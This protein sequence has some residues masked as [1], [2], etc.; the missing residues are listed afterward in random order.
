MTVQKNHKN[1]SKLSHHKRFKKELKPPLL[2]LNMTTYSWLNE[3]MPEMLWAVLVIGNVERETALKFFRVIAGFV[4][5]NPDCSDVTHTGISKFPEGKT[6]E[7]I[8]LATGWSEEIKNVLRPLVWFEKLPVN[9]IWK[10][11]LGESPDKNEDFNKLASGVTETYWH[12]SESATDCRWIKFFCQ[13][14][15]GKMSFTKRMEDKVRGVFEYPNYGDLREIRPFIRASEIMPPDPDSDKPFH[16]DW[17]LS[18]WQQCFDETGCLPEESVNKKIQKRQDDLS[19]EL[20]KSRE[21]LLKQTVELRH[22]LIDHFF[23]EGKTSAIDARYETSFGITLYGLSLYIEIIFYTVS[24]SITGR[25]AMRALVECYITLK[26]LLEKEKSEPKIWDTFREYGNGQLKLLYL[27]LKET[28][29]SIGSIEIDTLDELANE[30][31]SVEFV[32]INLGNWDSENL[33]KIS[34]EVGLKDLY[35]KYYSYNSGFMHGTWGAVRESIYQK[36]LNP[37]HRLHKIPIYD[38]P[39]MPSVVTDAMEVTNGILECLS[40]AY[41][42]FDDRLSKENPHTNGKSD[43]PNPKPIS[44]NS[45][46]KGMHLCIQN[47]ERYIQS[48]KELKS[49]DRQTSYLLFL[50]AL[51]EMGKVPMI[52]N[53]LFHSDTKIKWLKWQ[54]RYKDHA[55][56][57]WFSKDLEDFDEK[58]LAKKENVADT[59]MANKKLDVSYVEFDGEFQ[60]PQ[61]VSEAE[62][63]KVESDC[64]RRIGFLKRNHKSVEEDEKRILDD[65]EKLKGMTEEQLRELAKK[66]LKEGGEVKTD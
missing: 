41:P 25:L 29:Q 42:K 37:L 23:K 24:L 45:A 38:L 3:R 46:A 26:Y 20:K 33:R 61:E 32:P 28:N 52:F 55:E 17:S 15:G 7:F 60:A 8:K 36:C 19:Q 58:R 63:A 57:F 35:D 13:I 16:S 56:K 44:A 53:A 64:E 22:N 14:L 47:A 54:R 5:K 6:T 43:E 65:Y 66:N 40:L 27:K 9:A 51:E 59:K 50:Y 21:Y 18:F 39:L 4:Q 11:F 12:Q 34:E 48:A 31:K 10:E 2:T 30:D 62:L 1:E 49:R